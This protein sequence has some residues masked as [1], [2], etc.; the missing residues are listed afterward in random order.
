MKN[1]PAPCPAIASLEKKKHALLPK[2]KF[3]ENSDFKTLPSD[4][5]ALSLSKQSWLKLKL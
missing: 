3:A 5:H 2:E 4:F 1:K